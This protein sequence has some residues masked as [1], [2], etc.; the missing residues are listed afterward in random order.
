LLVETE[1]RDRDQVSNKEEGFHEGKRQSSEEDG[2]K[3]VE[4]SL[5]G[6]LG[7]DLNYLL[8]IGDGSLLRAIEFDVGFDDSTAR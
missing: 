4:H 3:D 6:V 5:L 8:A 7:A 2:E 1:D